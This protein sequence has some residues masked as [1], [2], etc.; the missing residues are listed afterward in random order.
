MVLL[1]DIIDI[2]SIVTRPRLSEEVEGIGSGQILRAQL[3]TPLW[4]MDIVTPI[5]SLRAN[6][7]RRV[8]ALFNQLN[9]PGAF[10]YVYDPIAQFPQNDPTGLIHNGETVRIL[11]VSTTGRLSL[12]NAPV[13][14]TYL[15]GDMFHVEWGGRH[16][17]F[18]ISEE[19]TVGSDGTTLLFD[20]F[21]Y[22]PTGIPGAATVTFI[23]P[24]MK[25]QFVPGELEYAAAQ[26]DTWTMG[27]FSLRAIQK[28]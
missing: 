15:P 16:G 6:T 27:N 9:R 23:R 22:M 11:E 28:L 14:F 25:A 7:G 19:V 26:S 5:S 21:P 18:E 4:Q 13:G 12:Q 24:T 10:F 20:T 2:E 8:R 17:Y 3:S 1:N